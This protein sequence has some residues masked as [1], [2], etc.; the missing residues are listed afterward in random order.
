MTTPELLLELSLLSEEVGEEECEGN[1]PSLDQAAGLF[2]FSA[3]AHAEQ[4][5]GRRPLRVRR[6]GD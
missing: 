6:A 2:Y 1:G 5:Q 4:C 3:A